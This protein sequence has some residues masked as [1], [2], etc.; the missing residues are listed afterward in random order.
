MLELL[1]VRFVFFLRTSHQNENKQSAIVL[2]IIFQKERTDML[3][4]LYCAEK[5]WDRE[6]GRVKNSDER[7]KTVNENLCMILQGAK[8]SFDELRFSRQA[9]TIRELIDKI[10]GNEDK[11]TLLIDYLKDRSRTMLKRVGSEIIRATYNKYAKSVIYMQEFLEAE[12]KIKNINLVQLKM[13]FIEGY[14]QFLRNNKKIGHNTACKYLTC[15]RTLLLPAVREGIVKS[16]PFYG[17]R[18]SPKPVVRDFLTQ[19]EL[20]K[21]SAVNLNDPDLDRKRDIFLF[22]CYT[23][24]AYVDLYQF[25]SSHLVKDTDGSWYIR[26]PRQKTGQESIIPLLPAAIRI[27]EKYSA[28]KNIANF[29]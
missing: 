12:Y 16:D 1:N 4:G 17:L 23:G 22:A 5:D 24:L 27:L 11:P 8:N 29:R 14:F 15:I 13:S 6:G 7:F 25:N 10:K 20:D 21:I 3:T 28:K 18:I 2:R 19:E 26:K 9:F